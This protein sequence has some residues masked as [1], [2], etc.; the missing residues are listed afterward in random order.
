MEEE[1][2]N[3]NRGINHSGGRSEVAGGV[4][5]ILY[6]ALTLHTPRASLSYRVANGAQHCVYNNALF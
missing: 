4:P 6:A 5:D 2:H 1:H 3:M